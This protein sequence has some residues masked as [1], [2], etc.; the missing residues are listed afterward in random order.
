[1]P[2]TKEGTVMA[3][4]KRKKAAKKKDAGAATAAPAPASA[5]APVPTAA[6]APM[7]ATVAAPAA[8]AV[9][10]D[11]M[12]DAEF[13]RY[14]SENNPNEIVPETTVQVQSAPPQYQ[15][16]PAPAPAQYQPPPA[17]APS[18]PPPQPT[19]MTPVAPPQPRPVP[20]TVP[21]QPAQMVVPQMPPI[22]NLPEFDRQKT[23]NLPSPENAHYPVLQ[24]AAN[25]GQALQ[26]NMSSGFG[27]S[28]WQLPRIQLA[29]G[30]QPFYVIH[31]P[32]GM[33]S[34]E[35]F[36]G[37]ILFLKDGRS[38]WYRDP[39]E[40][41]GNM[42]PDCESPDGMFGRGNPGGQCQICPYSQWGSMAQLHPTTKANS[43]GQACRHTS[44]VFIAQPGSMLPSVM[45]V[46]PTSLKGFKQYLFGLA[47]SAQ[48]YIDVVT[49]FGI[50]VQQVGGF[51]VSTVS[52]QRVAELENE[53]SKRILSASKGY[54]TLFTNVVPTHSE[55]ATD[56]GA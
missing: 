36:Q 3:K 37:I 19:L 43:K 32:E 42:P 50:S 5:P 28:A 53:Q 29:R 18:A 26:F 2:I 12:D 49:H 6:P 1:M 31:T 13:D 25:A 34:V 30:G 51:N 45:I 24:M 17:P 35:K 55:V 16:P 22:A 4:A 52:C 21:A 44:M 14:V 7:P 54:A 15:P 10:D 23:T 47:Q 27:F 33:Q 39:G 38:F 8:V 9:D 46:P 48:R 56:E 11:V 41:G 20:Q 40:S